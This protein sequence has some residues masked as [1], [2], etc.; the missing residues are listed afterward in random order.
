MPDRPRRPDQLS[1]LIV[2]ATAVVLIAGWL[3]F[4]WHAT[5]GRAAA[6]ERAR[7]VAMALSRALREHA[8]QTLAA[9]DLALSSLDTRPDLPG[10]VL[11]HDRQQNHGV[12]GRLRASGPMFAD[13]NVVDR[14][15]RLAASALEA[16][17]APLD[18]SDRSHFA[19]HRDHLDDGLFVA[20]P[21]RSRRT[22][23]WVLPLSRRLVDEDGRFAGVTT[24][25]LEPEYFRQIYRAAGADMVA[26]VRSDGVVMARFP[27][28]EDPHIGQRVPILPKVTAALER[29]GETSLELVSRFDGVTRVFGIAKVRSYPLQVAVAFDRSAALARWR[30]DLY[31]LIAAALACTLVV[32]AVAWLLL[33]RVRNQVALTR[34]LASARDEAQQACLAAEAA[35]HAKS[36]FLAHMSH[37]LRTP[38]NAIN[39]FAEVMALELYGPHPDPRYLDYS[40]T[41]KSSGDHL[42]SIINNILDLAKVD[43]GKWEINPEPVALPGLLEDLGRLLRER[44]KSHGV[45]LSIGPADPLPDPITDRRLL[46]QVLLNL[47]TNGI[48]FTPR[49]GEVRIAVRGVADGVTFEVADTGEGMS[50]E[51]VERVLQPFGKGSSQLARQHHDTGL[52]LLL[53]RRFVALLGGALAIDSAPGCGTCMTVRLPWTIRAPAGAPPLPGAVPAAAPALSA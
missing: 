51:D 48:K 5:T 47:A 8:E 38:L 14:A 26:L 53:S 13:I 23:E 27:M 15:G 18:L 21:V 10:I 36:E 45:R 1:A 25:L 32:L 34:R 17:P 31:P 29:N 6:V 44:A 46:L 30:H 40:R 9:V 28:G 52:G 3:L 37:E 50:A 11:G 39:G 41:I 19:H 22:G 42:L 4:A 16:A 24:A 20:D 12:L 33:Q 7:E 49:G 2:L 35:N 43:A